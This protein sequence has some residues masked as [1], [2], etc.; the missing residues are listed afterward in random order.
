MLAFHN[1][2]EFDVSRFLNKCHNLKV[3][4][5]EFKDSPIRRTP[6]IASSSLIP[7]LSALVHVQVDAINR[8]PT[9]VQ[10][11]PRVARW[12]VFKPKN[13]LAA[14]YSGHSVRLQNRRSRVRIPPGCKV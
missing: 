5:V 7:C 11:E 8:L 13:A 1:A 2:E 14:W 4:T 12:F 6:S 10:V 3:F 9:A